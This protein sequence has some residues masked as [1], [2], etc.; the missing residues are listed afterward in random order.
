MNRAGA[1]LLTLALAALAGCVERRMIITSEPA[2]A[3]V[4][5][6]D[7]FVGLTPLEVDFTYFGVYDVRLR[8]DGYQP[9]VTQRKA[10]APFHELPV[11]DFAALLIP[12]TKRTI[13]EWHFD[14]EPAVVD[15]D[16]LMERARELQR[17]YEQ[18][19]EAGPEG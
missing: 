18:G 7:A 12:T 16:A 11:I 6:N 5:L 15:N 13:I 17:E 14:L 4:R 9:L 8:K 10:K 2:G 19:G 3:E 1:L